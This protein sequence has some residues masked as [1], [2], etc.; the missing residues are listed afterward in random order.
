MSTVAGLE[1]NQD[2]G[3][4][5]RDHVDKQSLS[6]LQLLELQ[7]EKLKR[8]LS[9]SRVRSRDKIVSVAQERDQL[10]AEN[11]VLRQE[12]DS[13]RQ[14]FI[15]QQQQQIAFW[16]GPIMEMVLPK[17]RS[18]SHTAADDIANPK[19]APLASV[20]A[21]ASPSK[22]RRT[23]GSLS[24]ATAAFGDIQDAAEASSVPEAFMGSCLDPPPR[25]L[26]V[27]EAQKPVHS[28]ADTG[29]A[30]T[31][32]VQSLLKDRDHWQKVAG[33]LQTQIPKGTHTPI[34]Q[35]SLEKGTIETRS[36]SQ[37]SSHSS[38]FGSGSLHCSAE[39]ECG[40]QGETTWSDS[41]T[42]STKTAET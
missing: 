29:T 22:A 11:G 7:N 2:H 34:V 27:A 8:R 31:E 4:R 3:C 24:A 33:S 25:T 20:L 5:D 18:Q 19:V 39:S 42:E 41:G 35:V 32:C 9:K 37:R 40:G 36:I 13:L 38:N 17:S 28:S 26:D 30:R 1:D 15:R 12:C 6:S 23:V 10:S 16:A 21:A 14:L